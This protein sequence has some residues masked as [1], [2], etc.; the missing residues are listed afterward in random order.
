[1]SIIFL[2]FLLFFKKPKLIL[3]CGSYSQ[4]AALVI[5]QV[6]IPYFK[7]AKF[8]GEDFK[9]SDFFKNQVLIFDLGNEIPKV[10]RS[11]A[12]RLKS[13]ILVVTPVAEIP[14]DYVFFGAEKEKVKEIEDLAGVFPGSGRLVLNFDDETVRSIKNQSKAPS[15]T[16]GFQ[17]RADLFC[18][19][20]HLTRDPVLATN[21]K[22]NFEGKIIPVW[23]E[24]IFGKENVYAALAALAVSTVFDLNLVEVS[25]NLKDYQGLPGKL[26]IIEG[27]KNSLILD[28]SYSAS[29][30]SMIEALQILRKIEAKRKIAVLGD[31]IG[32][33]KYSIEAHEAIGE[34]A[35]FLDLLFCVGP[36]ARFIGKGAF[37]KGLSQERI[38]QFDSVE[39]AAK[40]LEQKIQEKDLILVDGSKE[41]QMLQLIKEIKL[42]K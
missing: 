40:V 14:P 3:V 33:G 5:E 26:R 9:I 16:F 20:L 36:R 18:S 30:F 23:L 41:M 12:K 38:F 29:V 13:P 11:V 17:Q 39:E 2:K 10:F 27:V 22:L 25:Q 34:R 31:V 42:I 24:K 35:N 15:L 21:F 32:I 7:V 19:D 37:K 28:N 4:S 8:K 1:M 6:L